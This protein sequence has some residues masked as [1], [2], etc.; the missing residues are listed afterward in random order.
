MTAMILIVMMRMMLRA[1]GTLTRV[2]AK[3]DHCA[4]GW[5]L[6]AQVGLCIS[7]DEGIKQKWNTG[8]ELLLA[9]LAQR[10][11][12]QRGNQARIS[13]PRCSEERRGLAER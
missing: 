11:E 2:N 5:G 3:G 12:L 4:R 6:Q 7:L 9:S 1:M 8:A 13:I 10:R